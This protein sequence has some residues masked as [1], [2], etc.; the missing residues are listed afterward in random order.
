MPRR[1]VDQR[2]D[3]LTFVSAPLDHDLTITGEVAAALFAS[4]S[5]SDADFVV[6][7]IDVYP[8]DAQPNAWEAEAGPA[9]EP[10]L[11]SG[12]HVRAGGMRDM[13]LHL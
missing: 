11:P 2:P 10:D 8:E 3:V 1:F 7:L 12:A 4:T 6:K 9:P 13:A 5:G